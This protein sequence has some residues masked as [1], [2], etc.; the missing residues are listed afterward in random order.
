MLEQQVSKQNKII[1]Q[2][3]EAYKKFQSKVQTLRD[4][5]KEKSVKTISDTT[6][7]LDFDVSLALEIT[8]VLRFH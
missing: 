7:D 5:L 8:I 2:K 6:K 3:E 4:N 1:L